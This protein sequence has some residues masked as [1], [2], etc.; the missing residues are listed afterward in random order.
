MSE[1]LPLSPTAF[2]LHPIDACGIAMI[3]WNNHFEL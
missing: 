1:C 3:G 2:P